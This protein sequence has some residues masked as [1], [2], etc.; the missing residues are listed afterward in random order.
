MDE[1]DSRF[2]RY[3]GELNG[4]QTLSMKEKTSE[5]DLGDTA[6]PCGHDVDCAAALKPQAE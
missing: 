3:I 2:G 6:A 4:R 1:F 5:R